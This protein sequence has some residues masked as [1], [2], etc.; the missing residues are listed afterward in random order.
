M[1]IFIIDDIIIRFEFHAMDN[2][3]VV[4]YNICCWKY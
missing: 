3:T 4:F 1:L 2:P